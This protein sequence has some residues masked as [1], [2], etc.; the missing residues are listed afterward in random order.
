M[1]RVTVLMAVFVIAMLPIAAVAQ[2]AE[3][4]ALRAA[5]DDLKAAETVEEFAAARDAVV[6]AVDALKAANP[7]LDTVTLEND[8]A[9]LTTAIDTG[10][11]EEIAGA[12]I[13][14]NESGELVVAAAQ[15]GEGGEG[16]E[17]GA[18]AQPTAVNT[19]SDVAT[20]PNVALLAIAGAMALLGG[21]ALVLRRG[22]HRG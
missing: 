14:V 7:D 11:L 18:T 4:D 9:N 22:A 6:A 16:G 10:D 5:L 15:E 8:L 3:I 2:T 21:G 13:V 1:R 19:G 17:G 20:G 12:S